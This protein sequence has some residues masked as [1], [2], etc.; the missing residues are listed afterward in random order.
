MVLIYVS[1]IGS[2]YSRNLFINDKYLVPKFSLNLL[3][4]GQLYELNL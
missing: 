4:I 3:S 2:I 1:Y